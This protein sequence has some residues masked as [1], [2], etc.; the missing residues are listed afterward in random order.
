MRMQITTEEIGSEIRCMVIETAVS[1]RRCL[2]RYTVH[3][4]APPANDVDSRTRTTPTPT[5]ALLIPLAQNHAA[6]R[7]DQRHSRWYA[8]HP[9]SSPE[10]ARARPIGNPPVVVPPA[11]GPAR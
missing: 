8:L 4:R 5:I 2:Q 1:P 3:H 7:R 11:P 6:P 10:D 9:L